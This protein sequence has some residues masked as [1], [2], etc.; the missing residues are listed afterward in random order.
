MLNHYWETSSIWHSL[1][2][3]I[4]TA[5]MCFTWFYSLI[6]QNVCIN[7]FC[8]IVYLSFTLSCTY[9]QLNLIISFPGYFLRLLDKQEYPAKSLFT[10]SAAIFMTENVLL[11]LTAEGWSMFMI[12][13]GLIRSSPDAM[14]PGINSFFSRIKVFSK[15]KRGCQDYLYRLQGTLPNN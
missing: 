2:W 14:W 1:W 5:G 7:L 13:Y 4:R 6:I 11:W 3:R 10:H 8:G 12:C 9:K 15:K